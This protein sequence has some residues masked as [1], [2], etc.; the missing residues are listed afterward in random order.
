ME[1]A[2]D[3]WNTGLI[4]YG[5]EFQGYFVIFLDSF[6]KNNVVEIVHRMSTLHI[7]IHGPDCIQAFSSW[8]L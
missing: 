4:V 3:E 6:F 7:H 8:M 1:L 5:S 2:R